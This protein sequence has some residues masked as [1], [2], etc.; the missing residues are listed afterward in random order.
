VTRLRVPALLT[1][2]LLAV[3]DHLGEELGVAVEYVP[4]TDYAASVSLFR[5]GDLDMGRPAGPW[6]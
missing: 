6:W 2:A 1:L 3:A 4:V 5:A